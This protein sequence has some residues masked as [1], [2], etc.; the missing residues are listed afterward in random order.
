[1]SKH[2]CCKPDPC[3][4]YPMGGGYPGGYGGYPMGGGFGGGFGG[5]GFGGNGI[6][7]IIILLIFFCGFGRGNNNFC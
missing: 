6:W 4:G 1:M 3:C 5:C 2:C 7:W